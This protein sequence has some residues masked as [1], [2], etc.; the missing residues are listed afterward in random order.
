MTDESERRASVALNLRI[1]PELRQKLVIA[2]AHYDQT[3]TSMSRMGLV[4]SADYFL[5]IM[6]EPVMLADPGPFGCSCSCNVVQRITRDVD[7]TGP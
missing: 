5:R 1:M 4:L 2:A 3:I 6:G 7:P